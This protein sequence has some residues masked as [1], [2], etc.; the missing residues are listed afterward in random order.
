MLGVGKERLLNLGDEDARRWL[1]DHISEM[2]KQGGIDIYRND[3]N[4]DPLEYWRGADASDRQGMTEIRYVEGLSEFWGELLRRDPNLMI[5]NCASGGRRID[6]ETMSRS[7]PLCRTDYS[8]GGAAAQAQGVGLGLYL[9]LSATGPTATPSIPA[10]IPDLYTARSAMSAGIVLNWDPRRPAFDEGLARRIVKEQE[11]IAKFYYGNW[12]PLTSVTESEEAWFA[13]QYHR[14]DLGEGM[15]MAFRRGKATDKS[16]TVKLRGLTAEATYEL[17]DVD[18]Q[19]KMI[20][21]GKKLAEGLRL[22]ILSSPGSILL[23]YRVRK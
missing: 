20:A 4:M 2:I 7:V 17:E 8:V 16:I 18:S 21:A 5:D 13:Y 22:N 1:T 3:F 15:I 10:D 12:Y 6:L 9:P 11:R 23:T 19:R 14:Q